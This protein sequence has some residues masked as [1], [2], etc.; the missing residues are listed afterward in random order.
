MT[1]K[2]TALDALISEEEKQLA[3]WKVEVNT[4]K[5]DKYFTV[6]RMESIIKRLTSSIEFSKKC[7][8]ENKERKV[9]E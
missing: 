7:R 3:Y 4:R 5:G 1:H 2:R 8:D 6:E 9:W